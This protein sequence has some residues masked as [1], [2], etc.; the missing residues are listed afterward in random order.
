MS[1]TR[2]RS[3][4]PRSRAHNRIHVFAVVELACALAT[5]QH[6]DGVGANLRNATIRIVSARTAARSLRADP[7]A[8][9]APCEL[10]R[11]GIAA[12]R[13]ASSSGPLLV[14]PAFGDPPSFPE[15]SP[16]REVS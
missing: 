7:G 15:Q 10:T 14:R 2:D 4:G 3:A 13:Q 11:V 5:I 12:H 8:A 9:R 6:S 16:S 1:A